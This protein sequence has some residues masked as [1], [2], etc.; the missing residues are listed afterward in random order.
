MPIPQEQDF[1]PGHPARHDYAPDSPAAKEWT[2]L[3]L[4]P[5]GERDFPV[6]HKKAVDTPGNTNHL[7]W[8]PGVD[9]HHPELEPFTGREP[10]VAARTKEINAEMA[11]AAKESTPQQPLIAPQPPPPGDISLP[12]GQPGGN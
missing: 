3:N 8:L 6:D 2:R 7:E 4:H 1:P 11:K 9:P 5:L 10:H 12:L